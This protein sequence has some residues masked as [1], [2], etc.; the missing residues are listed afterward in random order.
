MPVRASGGA[1]GR[2]R[3]ARWRRPAARHLWAE[4]GIGVL[5]GGA[6]CPQGVGLSRPG[7]PPIR[8]ALVHQAATI[9]EALTRVRRVL[10]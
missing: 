10:N 2:G 5:P 1:V 8:L 9:A 7:A 3:A 4:P 6:L